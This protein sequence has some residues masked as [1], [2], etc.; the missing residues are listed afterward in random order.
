LEQDKLTSKEKKLKELLFSK[1][2]TAVLDAL[3]EIKSSGTENFIPV[4]IDLLVKTKS[5]MVY[6]EITNILNQLK[7]EKSTDYL[8][9]GML[10]PDTKGHRNILAGAL[11]Q[12]GLKAEH[13]L[14][15]IVDIAIAEDYMTSIE[16]LTVI[17]NFTSKPQDKLLISS[18]KKLNEQLLLKSD[19]S[20]VYRSIANILQD[21]LM[22]EVM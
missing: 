21:M 7:P 8:I 14:D 22:G 6:S 2:D 19:K 10:S 18:L 12:A 5:A 15:V 3:N 20:E 16:C 9:A 1:S 11:W 17:E 4:L 13:H